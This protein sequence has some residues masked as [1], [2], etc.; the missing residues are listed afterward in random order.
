[1]QWVLDWN[2][3]CMILIQTKRLYRVPFIFILLQRKKNG[4]LVWGL[5]APNGPI[6]AN[7]HTKKNLHI[8]TK[9]ANHN[10]TLSPSLLFTLTLSISLCIYLNA[11]VE[12]LLWWCIV[13]ICVAM[14]WHWTTKTATIFFIVHWWFIS[15]NLFVYH[16]HVGVCDEQIYAYVCMYTLYDCLYVLFKWQQCLHLHMIAYRYFS[17]R[18]CVCAHLC[19]HINLDASTIAH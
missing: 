17:V 16:S 10:C 4:F 18:V 3:H 8:A 11:M 9:Y 14:C 2:S 6:I 1:M 12:M 15:F 19:V 7:A 5:Y 13:T